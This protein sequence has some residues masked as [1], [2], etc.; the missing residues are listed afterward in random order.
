MKLPRIFLVILCNL[1]ILN[2]VNS[3][4]LNTYQFELFNL[5]SQ[6]MSKSVNT[7]YNDKMGYIWI[8]TSDGLMRYDGHEI[9]TFRTSS[10]TPGKMTAN[11][12]RDIVA[13]KSE[14][15]WIATSEGL[16]FLEPGKFRIEAIN[17]APLKSQRINS[18]IYDSEGLLWVGTHSNGIVK[19]NPET[20]EFEHFY[21]N[22]NS[23]LKLRTNTVLSLYED[24]RGRIWVTSWKE[25]MSLISED[26]NRIDFL[27][28]VGYSDNTV[29]V[30]EDNDGLIWLATWDN[31][32]YYVQENEDAKI[33]FKQF[34]ISDQSTADIYKIVFD[35]VQDTKLNLIW[36]VTYDGLVAARKNKDGSLTVLSSE[37]FFPGKLNRTFSE[38]SLDNHG[39]L[40]LASVAE[41]IYRMDF[42][43]GV[44]SNYSMIN[45]NSISV[46]PHVTKICEISPE[47]LLISVDRAG[48]FWYNL[49]TGTLSKTNND[50][51]NKLNT[52]GE[53]I[54]LKH[55][56]EIW[57]S[58]L[59][60][61]NVHVMKIGNN[62]RLEYTSNF[63]LSVLPKSK[64]NSINIMFEDSEKNVWFGTRNG[65]YLKRQGQNSEKI[66]TDFN[67]ITSIT[68]DKNGGMWFGTL[69]FGL[70]FMDVDKTGAFNFK[71]INLSLKEQ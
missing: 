47:M 15:I 21:A 7:I 14:R 1:A 50:F 23:T 3:S 13:D 56:K 58:H 28:Q 20:L 35:I 67:E 61:D 37:Q 41:G 57:I 9:K 71:K 44:V 30:Y 68:R 43:K 60:Q 52:V 11:E 45:D 42:D 18:V 22:S 51:F 8:G 32:V 19:M 25:G 40:W 62:N 55:K 2:A 29:K 5:N 65:L 33:T 70:Q 4:V 46:P 16:M 53:M 27:P 36:L 17:I 39:N 63:H 49:K 54:Y 69:H 31:G 24:S 38:I 6:L 10:L 48:P 26:R 66:K 64:E 59:G 34:V 12:I